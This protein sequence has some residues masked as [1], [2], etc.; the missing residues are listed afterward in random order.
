[1]TILPS[2]GQPLHPDLSVCYHREVDMRVFSGLRCTGRQHIGNYLGAIQNF[3]A[4]QEEHEC[5]YCAVDIHTLTSLDSVRD[6]RQNT[7]DLVLDLLAAGVD[8]ERSI[9]FVQSHVPEVVELATL[10]GMVTPLSW[11]T[12]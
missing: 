9:I 6:L 1:M 5:I 7:I 2:K 10:L 3:V 11:L 4:L 8:P 12:R